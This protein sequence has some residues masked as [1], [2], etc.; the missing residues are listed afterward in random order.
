MKGHLSNSAI[1]AYIN[2][3]SPEK[4]ASAAAH[5]A[6]CP[7]CR[8]RHA[9]LLSLVTPSAGTSLGPG[10][11]V[12]QRI[13][14]TYRKYQ[15]ERSSGG[16]VASMKQWIAA[17]RPRAALAA[18]VVIA[19]VGGTLFFGIS[20]LT[21]RDVL[22]IYVYYYKGNSTI[23][24]EKVRYH[25]PIRDRSEIRVG[26]GSV[27]ILACK[28]RFIVKLYGNSEM[29]LA[30]LPEKEQQKG[31]QFVFNLRKGT[32]FTK[33]KQNSYESK[34]FYFTPN[35]SLAT[36]KSSFIMKVAGNRTIVIPKEGAVN[37]QSFVAKG[38]ITA[39]PEKDYV[40]SSSIEINEPAARPETIDLRI[41]LEHP[42]SH[43]EILRL[44]KILDSII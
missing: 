13:L 38:V 21:R 36:R 39:S 9:E 35:A 18:A 40:I 4:T 43:E 24:D 25:M 8:S 26:K 5:I 37:I 19:L 2:G 42:F 32:I 30:K 27:L 3:E 1:I 22:P 20:Y 16:A 41:Y 15:P 23:D 17:S 14:A 12:E 28:H 33:Y 6:S 7:R 10:R 11:Q 31:H 29:I 44:S 34:Y